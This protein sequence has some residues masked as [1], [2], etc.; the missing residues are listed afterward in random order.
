MIFAILFLQSYILTSCFGLTKKVQCALI[1]DAKCY[2][3]KRIDTNQLF[4]FDV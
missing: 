3:D 1:K 2:A 4:Y